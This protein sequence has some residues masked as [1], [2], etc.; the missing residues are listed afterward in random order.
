[1][2]PDGCRGGV[3]FLPLVHD[4]HPRWRTPCSPATQERTSGNSADRTPGEGG[5]HAHDSVCRWK[6]RR[7]LARDGHLDDAGPAWAASGPI[8][9]RSFRA[10]WL[11]RSREPN[12][13]L[14]G[15][16]TRL[17]DVKQKGLT[18]RGLH[19]LWTAGKGWRA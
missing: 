7:T 15:A 13:K 18:A 4:R 10:A 14:R 9:G 2:Q 5:P 6:E 11:T 12:V 3:G 16:L 19:G 8:A 1:D 17:T